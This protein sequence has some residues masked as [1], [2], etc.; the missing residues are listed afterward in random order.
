MGGK[1]SGREKFRIPMDKGEA[2]G[3]TVTYNKTLNDVHVNKHFLV[4]SGSPLQVKTN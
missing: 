1:K 3:S 4:Q 2:K